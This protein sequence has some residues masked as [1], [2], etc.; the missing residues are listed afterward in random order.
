MKTLNLVAALLLATSVSVFA[1]KK[2][3]KTETSVVKWTGKKIGGSH[4]GEI[5]VKNGYFEFENDQIVAGEVVI[6]MNSLSNTDLEDEGYNQ[7]LVGHLK[8]DDFFGVEKYP[9]SSFVVTKTT[10]FKE[11]KASVTG[12]LTIKGKTE[13]LTFDVVKSGDSYTAQL[14]VDRSKFDVRYGSN[15]FFDNLGDKAINDIF[16]LEIALSVN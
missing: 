16:T 4:H 8:S 6:D 3:V 7:K 1:Q 12:K 2:E 10:K 13:E 5:E 15:S 9:T 14:E 11:G